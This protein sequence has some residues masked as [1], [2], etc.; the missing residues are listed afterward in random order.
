M[1]SEFAFPDIVPSTCGFNIV[2]DSDMEIGKVNGYESITEN[3]GER[4]YVDL[5]FNILRRADA[6]AIRSHLM[7]LRG[8]VNKS[9]IKDTSYQK[10]GSW[11]N[12]IRVKGSNQYGMYLDADGMLAS[13]TPIKANDRFKLNGRVHEV[14]DDVNSDANGNGR[15]YVANEIINIPAD[16][17]VL[18]H[19][20]EAL[21]VACRWLDPSEIKQFQGNKSYYRNIKLSFIEALSP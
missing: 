7:R 4:W 9:L 3:T 11:M 8:S 21:T 1:S 12:T 10:Q 2:P 6:M 17:T 5:T 16:N 14:L 20:V 18:T 19:Q 15:I 13:S